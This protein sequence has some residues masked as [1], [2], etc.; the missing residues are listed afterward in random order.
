MSDLLLDDIGLSLL[1]QLHEEHESR[2]VGRKSR[3]RDNSF[4]PHRHETEMI[5]IRL[6]AEH[7]AHLRFIR[8]TPLYAPRLV[9][10]WQHFGALYTRDIQKKIDALPTSSRLNEF[11]IIQASLEYYQ[12]W[13]DTSLAR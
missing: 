10:R 7:L 4:I 5:Y 12:W 3:E 1:R 2:E 11:Q 9:Y 6:C 8:D 13:L